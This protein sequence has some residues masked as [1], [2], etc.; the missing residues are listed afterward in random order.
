MGAPVGFCALALRC[1]PCSV[2]MYVACAG[3]GCWERK[4]AAG[5]D[6]VYFPPSTVAALFM[7]IKG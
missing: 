1:A 2:M 4:I 7:L 6:A 5:V 3:I